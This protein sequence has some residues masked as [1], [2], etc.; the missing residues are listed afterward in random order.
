MSTSLAHTQDRADSDPAR[1]FE[2]PRDF[3]LAVRADADAHDRDQVRDYR[4]RSLTTREGFGTG[5]KLAFML[6]NAF[7]PSTIRAAAGSDEHGVYSDPY[8]GFLR[9]SREIAPLLLGTAEADPTAGR[10]QPLPMR[11]PELGVSARVDKDHSTSVSGG[12]RVHRTPETAARAASRMQLEQIVLAATSLHGFSYAT[13]EIVTDSFE[14]FATLLAASYRTE[15][16]DQ[17]L[18]EKIRGLGGSEFLGALNSPCL[19]TA[20]AEGGQTAATITGTNVLAMSERCWGYNRAIWL[21]NHDCRSQLVRAHVLIEGATGG[22]LVKVYQQARRDGEPDMLLGRPIFYSEHCST[23]GEVGDVL[24]CN[25]SQYLEGVYQPLQSMESMH[26]RWETHERAFKFW[27][28]NAGAPWWV[29]ELTP[30]NSET[31]L[32]PIVTLAART[33]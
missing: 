24:L 18:R 33:S 7:A 23:L 20:D 25:W 13:D 26:V 19:I 11:V 5:G 9:P 10:T 32:S 15:I 16:G 27:L 31:T 4:L 3:L 14:A 8:G 12:L 17:L 28:R 29:S 21:A 30:A 6:P 2:S 1:G 22:G